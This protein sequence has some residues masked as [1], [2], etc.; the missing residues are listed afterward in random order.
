CLLALASLESSGVRQIGTTPF[1]LFL[2]SSPTPVHR[3][4]QQQT[5]PSSTEHQ[6]QQEQQHKGNAVPHRPTSSTSNSDNGDASSTLMNR[7]Y[8]PFVR[9]AA[10]VALLRTY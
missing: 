2:R 10:F 4:Q 8:G 9:E 6:Q 1:H 3:K 7:Y 5:T